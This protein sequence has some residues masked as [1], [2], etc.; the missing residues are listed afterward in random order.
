MSH[1]EVLK[2]SKEDSLW[3]LKREKYFWDETKHDVA[4]VESINLPPYLE[5]MKVVGFGC[6]LKW[7]LTQR[8]PPKVL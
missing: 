1:R 2:K 5:N 8:Y 3:S 6:S 7:T 4:F